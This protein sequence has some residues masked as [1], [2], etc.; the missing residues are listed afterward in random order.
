MRVKVSILRTIEVEVNN[1]AVE[2]LDAFWRTAITP[3]ESTS[4]IEAMA[5]KATKAIEEIVGLPFGDEEATETI[6]A[7]CAMDGEPILEW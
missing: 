6:T 7:V 3:F 5:D 1:P 4:K 2:K